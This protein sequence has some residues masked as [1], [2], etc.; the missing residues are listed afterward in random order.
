MG[1]APEL[2]AVGVAALS[3]GN[4]S[5][6]I[7]WGFIADHFHTHPLR[8]GMGAFLGVLFSVVLLYGATFQKGLYFPAGFFLGFF[9]GAPLVISPHQ[10]SSVYGL[11]K[12][13]A[14]YPLSASFHGFAASL[15][16]PIAGL[17]IARTGLYTPILLLGALG[18]LLGSL[19]Y[20]LLLRKSSHL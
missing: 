15:G 7:S 18:V 1:L 5:G 10:L 13:S 16:A 20:F 8:V 3:V 17:I 12:L 19:A 14:V 2:A 4:A 11:D 6:R 9:F